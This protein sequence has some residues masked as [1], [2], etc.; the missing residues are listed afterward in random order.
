M[1]W[2]GCGSRGNQVREFEEEVEGQGNDVVEGNDEN[3]EAKGDEE[4]I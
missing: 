3:E 2:R 1:T 4:F